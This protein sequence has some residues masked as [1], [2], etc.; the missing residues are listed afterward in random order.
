MNMIS[1]LI[2]RY[3]QDDEKKLAFKISI[4]SFFILIC[5]LTAII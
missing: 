2:D 3:I 1:H 4:A 5:I